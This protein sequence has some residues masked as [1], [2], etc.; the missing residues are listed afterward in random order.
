MS[1]KECDNGTSDGNE[2]KTVTTVTS[3]Q[4]CC[5]GDN[6]YQG[7]QTGESNDSDN[8]VDSD[9]SDSNANFLP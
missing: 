9:N 2:A 1:T 3:T 7:K 6:I 5:L 4:I 8:S